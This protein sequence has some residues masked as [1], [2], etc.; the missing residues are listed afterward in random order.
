MEALCL[1]LPCALGLGCLALQVVYL[2]SYYCQACGPLF[3]PCTPESSTG[4]A[5]L[6]AQS[7]I[8]V[9]KDSEIIVLL[10]EKKKIREGTDF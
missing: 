4:P 2:D 1:C 8:V 10:D 9:D 7:F 3:L 6:G 5:N